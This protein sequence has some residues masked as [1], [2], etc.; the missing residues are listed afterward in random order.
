MQFKKQ[1]QMTRGAGV[2]MHI[3]SLPSPYGIGTLGKSAHDFVD[4]LEKSNLKYWQVL[5]LGH[6]SYGDSPYSSFSAFAGNPYFIDLDM[7]IEEGLLVKEEVE[8]L[9]FGTD[10][11]FVDYAKLYENRF[12]L[13]YSAY[14]KSDFKTNVNY[15]KFCEKNLFWLDDYAL[16]MSIKATQQEHSWQEWDEK[17]KTR[18]KEALSADKYETDFWKF[19]QF[20]FSEQWG[21]LKSYA[22]SKGIQIVGDIPIYVALDSAD[23]WANS[24]EFLL[25][26]RLCP[27]SVAGVP[28]DIFSKT[29]QLWG[30]PIYNYKKMEQDNFRWWRER[31]KM[32]STL[33]DVIRIDHFVGF[34]HYY[35]IPAGEKTSEN[36]VWIEGPGE[37]ILEAICE[38]IGGKKIIAED[39][40]NQTKKVR[41]LLSKYGIPGMKLLQFAFDSDNKNKNL[42]KFYKK[43]IVVYGGTHD[44]ETLVGFFNHNKQMLE[45][46]K[47]YLGTKEDTIWEI[48][49]S[50]FKSS[51]NIAIFQIQDYLELDN[52]ARMNTP[53]TLGGN[54]IWRST[55]SILDDKLAEKIKNLVI[56][57][58]R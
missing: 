15:I 38:E 16:F 26:E 41:A 27:T 37:K 24:D 31:M 8:K 58:N 55:A 19:I 42:P 48:I 33:Y 17:L 56:L 4:F 22:N 35:S 2:L 54:W 52:I 1:K 29:G 36:G 18:D 50:G 47:K 13:L 12:K 11:N 45:F 44:N 21:K 14:K 30:N 51:A 32:L 39:L 7:L 25:D 3:S 57:S 43:N 5:P 49:K 20:K 6:T 34:V 9:D 28:P 10:C 23:V 53:S 40:G 46:A